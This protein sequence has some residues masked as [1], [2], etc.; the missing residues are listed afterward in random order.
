MEIREVQFY[1]NTV[2]QHEFIINLLVEQKLTTVFEA[3]L[4]INKLRN[5]ED[6]T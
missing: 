2:N 5:T 3:L 1:Y 4:I 6:M